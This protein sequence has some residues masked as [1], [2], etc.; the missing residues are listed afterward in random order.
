MS[1]S[2]ELKPEILEEDRN[3]PSLSSSASRRRR[4]TIFLC[5]LLIAGAVAGAAII[6][7]TRPK[8]VKRPPVKIIPL[9]Q[10]EK[11]YPTNQ[12]ITIPAMGTVVP[13][14]ETILKSR[15][16]GE[17]VSIHPE[18]MEGG[19]IQK[20]EVVLQIDQED[21]KLA[22][23]RKESAV[24]E[25][26]YSLKV[27]MGYQEVARREWD[28]L[29][30]DEPADPSDVELA[31]RKPYLEKAQADLSAARA[32]L[33]QANLDLSRTTVRAPFNSMIRKKYVDIGSQVSA[34]GQLAEIVGTDEYWI[35]VSVPVERLK[36]IH[37]P[38]DAS[39]EG[40]T[41]RIQVR[42]SHERSG[43][44]IK[45]LGDLETEGRMARVMV[46]VPDP[47]CL[48]SPDTNQPPLLIGEYV[49]VEINGR[50][51][52]NGYRIPQGTLHDSSKVW[53]AGASDKLEIRQAEVI[54]R[55]EDTVLIGSGLNPGDRLIISDLSVP[56]AGMPV[57]ID[58]P[59]PNTQNGLP[60]SRKTMK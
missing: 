54:W 15:V 42:N 37:F 43:R 46:S 41:V 21:H 20:G 18:F 30:N 4:Y 6:Q 44:V 38:R 36:W 47:F 32:E 27:E 56:I 5:L 60:L 50:E 58:S 34:L 7:K 13:A 23:I 57:K 12:Q 35:L 17:V 31:L 48:K 3:K 19:I 9:V 14:H 45:L 16:L 1:D 39:D 33:A 40:S 24:I 51:I 26:E 29:K 10:T 25:A 28:L 8:A 22:V 11:V 52:E 2:T 53:V 59:K 55:D 49:R